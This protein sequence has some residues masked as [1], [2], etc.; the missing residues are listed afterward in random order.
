MKDLAL[1]A[2]D[3]VTG[4]GTEY[5]D[6]RAIHTRDLGAGVWGAGRRGSRSTGGSITSSTGAGLCSPS[7]IAGP[8][9]SDRE[10]RSLTYSES[11]CT[12]V[13]RIRPRR[14][15]DWPAS[16]AF[17]MESKRPTMSWNV[18]LPSTFDLLTHTR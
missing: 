2:L 14:I 18:R 15:S 7:D 4:R 3:L 1:R 16:Q 10:G 5:A 17:S 6:V 12:F 13:S 8:P 11:G 9:S